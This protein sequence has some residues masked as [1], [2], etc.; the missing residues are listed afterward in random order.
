MNRLDDLLRMASGTMNRRQAG[1]A[2]AMLLA[3]LT[4]GNAAGTRKGNRAAKR[5][6]P[7]PGRGFGRRR[8]G[9]IAGIPCPAGFTCV[10]DPRDDCDPEAGGADCIGICVRRV[11]D[12]CAAV[13]CRQGTKCCP[14][15]GGICVPDDVRCANDLCRREPCN[16]ATCGPGEYCC[17]E[18][19]SLCVPLGD[20]C[21]QEVCPPKGERCGRNRCGPGEFCCNPSC[22]ICAPLGGG[23]ITVVCDP[24]PGR[25]CG[26]IAG[27][28]CP[29]GFV[30]VD[31][32]RDDCD[33]AKGGADCSGICV[34]R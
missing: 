21:T 11:K 8:C 30:C 20:A 14:R 24:E 9:G 4:G 19:C 31:D 3:L 5:E 34:P 12:P 33:P 15:C 18:S 29:D 17:N 22:G 25:M 6:R 16:E 13:R 32:P 7:Q 23:C 1:L 10:D 27:I 2:G 28:P 26:G